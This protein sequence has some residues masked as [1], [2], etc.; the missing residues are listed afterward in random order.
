MLPFIFEAL[1]VLFMLSRILVQLRARKCFIHILSYLCLSCC[2][3][4]LY[5]CRNL[6]QVCTRTA[7]QHIKS[8]SVLFV[9]V[10]VF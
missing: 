1:K 6:A 7:I 4:S 5:T 10:R 8:G 9:L 3:G 2:S